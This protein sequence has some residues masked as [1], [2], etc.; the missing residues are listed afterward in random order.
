VVLVDGARDA[1]AELRAAGL[2]VAVVT[3]QSG[4][5][6]GLLTLEQVDAVNRRIDAEVGRIDH[7]LVCPH[8]PDDGCHCRKPA[9]GLVRSAAARLGV[10]TASCVVIGDTEADV[11][12]ARAAGARGILV[13]NSA[14]RPEE[15][16]WAPESAPTLR[17][18]VE[19]VLAR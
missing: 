1:V 7:W 5:A 8:G 10:P 12:A 16:A 17:A 14:T 4:V 3:N 11:A 18:A 15:V 13:A 9:S 19:R 6:R 2:H